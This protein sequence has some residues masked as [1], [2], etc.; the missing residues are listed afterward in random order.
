MGSLKISHVRLVSL[1][2]II[3]SLAEMGTVLDIYMDFALGQNL[4]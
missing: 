4:L 2:D 1:F 3:A